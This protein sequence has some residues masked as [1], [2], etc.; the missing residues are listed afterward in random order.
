MAGGGN[1]GKPISLFY[2]YSHR[3]EELRD[4]LEE[5]LGGL[6]RRGLIENWHDRRIGAGSEWKDAIDEH[7]ATADIILLLISSSFI[8]SDYCWDKEMT[9]ALARHDKGEARVIPVVLKPCYW[10]ES[11][12]A[13]LQ[14][15]PRDAKPITSWPDP[16]EAFVQV[17][18]AIHRAVNEIRL[19]RSQANPP[20]LPAKAAVAPRPAITREPTVPKTF[21]RKPTAP[22]K[23][24]RSTRHALKDAL[25]SDSIEELRDQRRRI[26]HVLKVRASAAGPAAVTCR[27]LPVLQPFTVFSDIDAPW[28]PEMVVLPPGEFLMGS[29]NSDEDAAEDEK[30]QHRLI[31]RYRFAMG[32]YPVTFAEYDHFCAATKRKK[33]GDEGWGRGRR[34]VISA[35]W[36]DAKAYCAWLSKETGQ[37]YRLPSE[38][39]WE[40]AC[41]AG[42]TTRY[43]CGDTIVEKDANFAPSALRS[44]VRG[45]FG[46]GKTSVVGS[47]PPNPWGLH[48]MHGNVWEWVEDHFHDHYKGATADGSA[49]L[50]GDHEGNRVLR[51]GSWLEEPNVLRSAHRGW[52]R[53]MTRINT[54]GFRVA[55]TL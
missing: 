47:Y 55:R 53:P 43:S 54:F 31:I 10:Q 37:S 32:R 13:R 50:A 52:S 15:V 23:P 27:D 16:D 17:V 4:R 40:Y 11:L 51:G 42:T 24:V 14:M 9:K 44:L 41:R 18:E 36:E 12:F 19:R 45:L 7:L 49:R 48:D 46:E 20:A 29:P 1:Q 3:D 2:S 33:P 35:S 28:C 5:H 26:I 8:N 22:K 38:A 30:P 34:P 6:R 39:E 25:A 21:T